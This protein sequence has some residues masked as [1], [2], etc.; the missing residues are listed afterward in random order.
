MRT[1]FAIAGEN[2][3]AGAANLGPTRSYSGTIMEV[4]VGNFPQHARK[5][6]ARL[7]GLSDSGAKKKIEGDSK[8]SIDEF[9][10][11]L[12]TP[13]GFQYLTAV[14][15]DST[16]QWWRILAPLMELAEVQS[17]QLRARRKFQRVVQGAL[18]ADRDLAATIARA[19]VLLVQ[20]EDFHRPHAD[21]LRAMAGLPDR[22]VAATRRR[23]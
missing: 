22:A 11:M 16:V 4:F 5:T 10:T 3:K 17:M 7:L 20:D 12:R 19:E 8:L 23:R 21:A 18:D 1:Q 15:S 13:D 6:L 14:M 9:A 2:A